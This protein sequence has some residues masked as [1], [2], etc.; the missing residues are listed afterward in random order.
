MQTVAAEEG[1]EPN[2][3]T[4]ERWAC[5]GEDGGLPLP[6]LEPL[7][8]S[9]GLP[10]NRHGHGTPDSGRVFPENLRG[11]VTHLKTENHLNN[12]GTDCQKRSSLLLQFWGI[13]L[14]FEMNL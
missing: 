3:S 1:Q 4:E 14:E 13:Y 11:A 6:G 7:L 8:C 9:G 5:T 10:P 12:R 2:V